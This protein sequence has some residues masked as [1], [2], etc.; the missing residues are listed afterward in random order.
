M[1]AE[2]TMHLSMRSKK[3][4]AE[5]ELKARNRKTTRSKLAQDFFDALPLSPIETPERITLPL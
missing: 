4:I 3:Q 1:P 2:N 5:A